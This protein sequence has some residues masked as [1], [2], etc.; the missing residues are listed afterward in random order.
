MRIE[1]TCAKCGKNSFD[2]GHGP[3]DD[4]LI[5]CNS[6]GPKIGTMAELKERLAAEVLKR[7]AKR[8]A[9]RPA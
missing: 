4:S 1:L 2:L 9:A 8:D 6:C 5:R 7:A 3:E